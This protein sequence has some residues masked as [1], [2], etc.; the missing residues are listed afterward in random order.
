MKKAWLAVVHRQIRRPRNRALAH[1]VAFRA[2]ASTATRLA[3]RLWTADR[4]GALRLVA[5]AVAMARRAVV[6]AVA[7]VATK[8]AVA[9]AMVASLV[10]VARSRSPPRKSRPSGSSWVRLNASALGAL[11]QRGPGYAAWATDVA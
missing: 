7:R 2:N 3:T 1:P 8:V 4:L 9:A 5:T 6:K 11:R 10:E